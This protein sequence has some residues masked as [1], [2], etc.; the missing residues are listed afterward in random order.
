MDYMSKQKNYDGLTFYEWICIAGL[1]GKKYYSMWHETCVINSAYSFWIKS[2]DPT[3]YRANHNLFEK[4]Y[5][6]S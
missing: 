4:Y 1:E 2:E 3:E 6:K 5:E